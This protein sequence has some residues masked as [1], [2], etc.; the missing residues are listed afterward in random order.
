MGM[1]TL[2]QCFDLGRHIWILFGGVSIWCLGRVDMMAHFRLLRY[3]CAYD[4]RFP[5]NLY[6]PVVILVLFL[7]RYHCLAI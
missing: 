5:V 6:W 3:L 2:S 4:L 7:L 1:S